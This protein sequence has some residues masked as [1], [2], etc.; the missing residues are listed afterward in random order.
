MYSNWTNSWLINRLSNS[1]RIQHSAFLYHCEEMKRIQSP[2]WKSNIQHVY[3]Q[4]AHKN[5]NYNKYLNIINDCL[6]SGFP[7]T[8]FYVKWN[9][10]QELCPGNPQNSALSHEVKT[11][12]GIHSSNMAWGKL[13]G[14]VFLFHNIFFLNDLT[15]MNLSYERL[16]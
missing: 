16:K 4:I 9:P 1:G 13:R 14:M 2:K 6:F 15:N 11:P 5:L 10:R 7:T 3:N 8:L 12:I